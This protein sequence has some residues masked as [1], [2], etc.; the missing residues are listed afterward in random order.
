MLLTSVC[1]PLLM[2]LSLSEANSS[3]QLVLNQHKIVNKNLT[4]VRLA[5]PDLNMFY[6]FFFQ[7][8]QGSEITIFMI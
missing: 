1:F 8:N 6:N 4:A 3:K 2:I 7:P 5:L